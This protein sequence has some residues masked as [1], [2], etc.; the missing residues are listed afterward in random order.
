MSIPGDPN[1]LPQS[2]YRVGDP[3][4]FLTIPGPFT[5]DFSVPVTPLPTSITPTPSDDTPA[6]SLSLEN[7]ERSVRTFLNDPVAQLEG[8]LVDTS[9][10]DAEILY[11]SQPGSPLYL[12]TRKDQEFPN[13]DTFIVDA[14]G[15]AMLRAIL[16]S[17]AS[18]NPLS[19]PL[20]DAAARMLA[21][22]F[23]RQHFPGQFDQ[24]LL[25]DGPFAPDHRYLIMN[26]DPEP[27]KNSV[28]FSWRL[29]SSENDGWLPTWVTVSIDRTTGKVVQY[30]A[31]MSGTD[32]IAPPT[33]T[34]QQA[35][36]IALQ[37]AGHSG[38]TSG[39]TATA[40]L[41]TSFWDRHS[42]IWVWVV[43]LNGGPASS[44]AGGTLTGV[45]INARTGKVTGHLVNVD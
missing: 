31:R 12:I 35:T 8:D 3:I 20:D 36:Q 34:E 24:L 16:P 4:A 33:V 44:V 19:A 18:G 10:G 15:G 27:S 5:F 26:P 2:I 17:H 38:S 42:E 39:V 1:G 11:P 14:N 7:A 6:T 41:M 45:V 32:Q 30:V 28:S 43:E 29:R 13:Q 37:E 21:E 23:A 40:G 22:Q 9:R 25:V